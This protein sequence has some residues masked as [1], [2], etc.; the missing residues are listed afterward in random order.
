MTGYWLV[1]PLLRLVNDL[2]N[3]TLFLSYVHVLICSTSLLQMNSK[4]A[5]CLFKVTA[6]SASVITFLSNVTLQFLQHGTEL[7]IDLIIQGGSNMTGTIC[8]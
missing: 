6:V 4:T 8:V 1:C 2:E 3:R 7:L 5:R